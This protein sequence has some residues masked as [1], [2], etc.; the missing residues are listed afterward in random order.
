MNVPRAQQYQSAPAR[1]R[2][3]TCFTSPFEGEVDAKAIG[4]TIPSTLL[5]RADLV[6]E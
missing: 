4:L 3:N 1:Q 5:A 2:R 6:I